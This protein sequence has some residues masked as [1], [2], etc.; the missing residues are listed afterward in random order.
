[1]T[2]IAETFN[3]EGKKMNNEIAEAKPL[4]K[5]II[6]EEDDDD[7]SLLGIITSP[8]TALNVVRNAFSSPMS[9]ARTLCPFIIIDTNKTITLHEKKKK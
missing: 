7:I 9:L 1:M 4:E 2:E 8:T 6:I 3:F 5:N